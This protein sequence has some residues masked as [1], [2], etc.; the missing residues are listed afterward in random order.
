[1]RINSNLTFLQGQSKKPRDNAQKWRVF[2][3]FTRL[4]KNPV[5]Y[6]YWKLE[7]LHRANR[8][9]PVW[10]LLIA[11]LY[12]SF[13]MYTLMKNKKERL[14]EHWYYKMGETNSTQGLGHGDTR[15]PADRKKNYVRYSNLHQKT[16]EKRLS[17]IFTNFW[18]RDQNFR[19]YFQMRKKNDIQPS[20]KGFYHEPIHQAYKQANIDWSQKRAHGSE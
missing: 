16:R 5:G 10:V 20:E 4:I 12:T 13:A 1:M 6:I 19:K 14:I 17:M 2:K 15:F 9:R 8:I 11:Q 3:N 7:P 18:C